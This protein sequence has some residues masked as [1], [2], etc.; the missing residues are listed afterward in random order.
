MPLLHVVGMTPFNTTFSIC[1]VFLKKETEADYVWAI[2][3]VCKLFSDGNLPET[4]V[5]NRELALMNV[6]QLL[7][8]NSTNLLCAWHINKNVTAKCKSS[9]ENGQDWELFFSMWVQVSQLNKTVNV[10]ISS[11]DV[12]H[13][14]CRAV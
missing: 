11:L 4:I 13:T 9:F 6:L 1:F 10:L 7:L 14:N 5:I 2:E 3:Q 8:P 12:S